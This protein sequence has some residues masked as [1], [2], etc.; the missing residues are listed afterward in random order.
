MKLST[1]SAATAIASA[2]LLV[3]TAAWADPLPPTAFFFDV[4]A[5]GGGVA[6]GSF[7]Y[8]PGSPTPG[9]VSGSDCSYG[10]CFTGT[11]TTTGNLA[12]VNTSTAPG[13]FGAANATVNY[14]YKVD[15]PDGVV[16]PLNMIGHLSAHVSDPNSGIGG[17]AYIIAHG[18]IDFGAF[19]DFA[20]GFKACSGV[21]CS[22]QSTEDLSVNTNF[23]VPSDTV[24]SFSLLAGCGGTT[25]D[26]N[27]CSATADPMITIDP[28]FSAANPGFSLEFSSN[29]S[30]TVG[31][32]PGV[33][34]PAAWAMMLVGFAGIG[35]TLRR[36]GKGAR[37]SSRLA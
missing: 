33:P 10:P 4:T 25:S 1:I 37:Q 16:V 3:S 12:S 8:A 18:G 7:I 17:F 21:G 24:L 28:T 19:V 34:E 6:P 20:N 14:S 27:S 22:P 23:Y 13:S 36:R 11:A 26:D 5:P 2:M 31:A 32:T 9:S 35:W 30:N 15:G 29:I